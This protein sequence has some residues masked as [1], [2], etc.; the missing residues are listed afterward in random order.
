MRIIINKDKCIGCGTCVALCP[1]FF[2]LGDD[3]KAVVK[4]NA[5]PDDKIVQDAIKSCPVEAITVEIE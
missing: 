1:E 3:F 2:E 5:N 4:E